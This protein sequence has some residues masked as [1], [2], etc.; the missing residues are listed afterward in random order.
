[1][2]A[3]SAARGGG[4]DTKPVRVAV[5]GTGIAGLTAA[6]ALTHQVDDGDST[7]PRRTFE[8][9]VFERESTLG[10]DA[11]S[12]DT[13]GARTDAPLRVF[14]EDYYPNLI[15]LYDRVGV[16]SHPANYAFSCTFA[17]VDDDD[18]DSAAAAA[19]AAGA[20][21]GR[22]GATAPPSTGRAAPATTTSPVPRHHT[23]AYFRYDNM[24]IMGH[25]VPMI[26][27]SLLLRPSY[28][29]LIR[30]LLGFFWTSPKHLAEGKLHGVSLAEY[31][32]TEGYTSEFS[33]LLLYPMLS[34]VCTC[35]YVAVSRYPAD[36][37]VDYMAV[38]WTLLASR[39]HLRAYTGTKDVV[40]KLTEGVKKVH[41]ACAVQSVTRFSGGA[42]GDD[43]GGVEVAYKDGAEVDAPVLTQRFDHVVLA[44]QA[45]TS[46][47]L[48]KDAS[49]DE[50]RGLGSF[51]YENSRVVVHTDASLLPDDRSQWS[52]LNIVMANPDACTC[53]VWMNRIDGMLRKEL[54]REVFQTWNPSDDADPA[55][56]H[57]DATFQRP[58]VTTKS[59][60]GM[61]LLT[62]QQGKQRTW[63][64][65]A[66]QLYSMPLLE[67]GV[68]SGLKVAAMMGAR[69]PISCTCDKLTCTCHDGGDDEEEVGAV[70]RIVGAVVRVVVV[71]GVVA[72]L[73]VAAN[74]LAKRQ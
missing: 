2:A 1:M 30:Q 47:H 23:S 14:R 48:L 29:S 64:C 21:D 18:R 62:A 66:Y 11:H 38:G 37:I 32:D 13:H 60:A 24:F 68:R 53:H 59:K 70:R 39:A 73:A 40:T 46:L 35:S 10:M 26:N 28:W 12:V 27:W 22:G 6:Y 3:P 8:V 19:A 25:V 71:G 42:D 9:T 72:G 57:M 50:R 43:G 45:N 56:V 31:L 5:V 51:A 61:D 55:T 49:E 4:D 33:E 17:K 69:V 67:N 7:A 15:R 65:G 54:T 44:T 20:G 34:V 74:K 36:I 58:V 63:F 52:P 41:T 16:P